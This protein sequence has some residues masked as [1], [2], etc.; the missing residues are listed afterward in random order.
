MVTSEN[1]TKIEIKAHV[2]RD[3]GMYKDWYVGVAN[4]VEARLFNDH[5]VNKDNS[6]WTY[7]LTNSPKIAR[8]TRQY[9][10]NMGFDG[11]IGNIDANANVVYIYK[12]A[13][14]TTP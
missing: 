5:K 8:R 4:D 13:A 10:L 7:R 2:D 14:C 12:K 1:V 3:G 6:T 9:F 11:G